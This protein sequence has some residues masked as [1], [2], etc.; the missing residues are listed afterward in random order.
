MENSIN[1][2]RAAHLI[3]SAIPKAL[4]ANASTFMEC[5]DRRD[6]LTAVVITAFADLDY[7]EQRV[8]SMRLGFDAGA[9]FAPAPVCR[10]RAIAT[11][12]ELTCD[13]TASKIFRRACR[14]IAASIMGA[15]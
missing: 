9:D 2:I 1:K 8:I 14:K 12:F 4:T 3:L 13:A 5:C 15:A 7:R 6:N 10:Y 11:A